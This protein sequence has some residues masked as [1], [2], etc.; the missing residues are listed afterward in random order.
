MK[1]LSLKL[2]SFRQ[3]KNSS[4]NFTDG[5]T[6]IVG[7]NG[8]GKTTIVEAIGF[9]LY[10][11]RAIRGK[12]ADLVTRNSDKGAPLE[13]SMLFEH[14]DTTIRIERTLEGAELYLGGES[15]PIA[16]GKTQVTSR[17]SALLGMNYEEFIAT[18]FTGQKGLEFLSGKNGPAERERFIVRMMGYD[19]LEKVQERLR[20][21]RNQT[22]QRILGMQ[23]GLGSRAEIEERLKREE[24]NLERL[25]KELSES[26]QLLEKSSREAESAQKAFERVARLKEQY[27]KYEREIR[28]N[29]IRLEE[30]RKRLKALEEKT[31]RLTEAALD[32]RQK[33]GLREEQDIAAL[34]AAKEQTFCELESKIKEMEESLEKARE[35]ARGKLS[36][37]EAECAFIKRE[38][39]TLS[40]R[41]K[42]LKTLGAGNSDSVCPTCGQ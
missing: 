22:K 1:L 6:A 24:H 9:A 31:A 15:K 16:S 42:E 18:F 25:K 30:S 10:G 36:S 2:Q 5:L 32:K 17:I 23:A 12:A 40:A 11:T 21:D 8:S 28:D 13:V 19:R 20:A 7:P 39:K 34:L 4:I 26:E 38:V 35:R 41:L 37:S 14:D 29:S 27:E 33:L 3:H